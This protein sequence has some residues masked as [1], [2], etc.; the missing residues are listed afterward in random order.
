MTVF[1]LRPRASKSTHR[2]LFKELDSTLSTAEF[3]C[4]H[5]NVIIKSQ[6]LMGL[7]FY[8]YRPYLY[9]SARRL[10]KIHPSLELDALVNEGFEG[11]LRALK[12]YNSDYA[13]FLTY[14]QHWVNM[15]MNTYAY[16]T[17]LA[18]NIPGSIHSALSKFKQLMQNRLGI[19]DL[20]LCEELGITLKKLKILQQA[21]S[22]HVNAKG[23]DEQSGMA[24]YE[25]LNDP[26]YHPDMADSVFAKVCSEDLAR[27]LREILPKKECYVIVSL[28]GLADGSPKVLERVG[29]V[30]NVSKERVRQIKEFAFDKLRE[31]GALN[32]FR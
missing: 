24:P 22:L 25:E 10:M 12:K 29:K 14:A 4:K 18:I 23:I 1:T 2:N 16:K 17:V 20:E 9:K 8:Q 27:V 26:K 5:K 6:R 11:M 21:A 31:S 7:F 30:L 28:F 3:I 15:K 32:E 13:S 19:T